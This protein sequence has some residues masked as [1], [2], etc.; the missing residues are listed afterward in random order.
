MNN[1]N[2]NDTFICE[3][4]G[5]ESLSAKL[6]HIRAGLFDADASGCDFYDFTPT[7]LAADVIGNVHIVVGSCCFDK[8]RTHWHEFLNKVL[9]EF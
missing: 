4:C 8:L 1:S 9:T 3:G 2:D 7:D 6:L 5:N